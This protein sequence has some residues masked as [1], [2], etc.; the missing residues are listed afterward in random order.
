MEPITDDDDR[1]VADLAAD[2]LGPLGFTAFGYPRFWLADHGW[3]AQTI[4]LHRP[5]AGEGLV[6]TVGWVHLWDQLE[7]FGY[8]GLESV[9]WPDGKLVNIGWNPA[10]PH[11]FEARA[12][13][14]VIL[15]AELAQAQ[16]TAHADGTRGLRSVAGQRRINEW[17]TYDAAICEGLLG[18]RARARGSLE[19]V[20]RLCSR[21][22]GE[23][24]DWVLA[25]RHD[26]ADLLER[27]PQRASFR[28]ELN[29]RIDAT[30]AAKGLAPV[31][32]IW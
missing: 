27:L 9:H 18:R 14:A 30:R 29:R 11:T 32:P 10:E 31:D 1:I 16:T 19:E 6:A 3:W 23:Q 24:I 26:A 21:P 2:V 4:G 22:G 8:Y 7:H 13:G 12:E 5:D 17:A 25:L 15:A 28:W 20:V